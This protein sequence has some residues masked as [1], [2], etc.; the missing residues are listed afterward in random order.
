MSLNKVSQRLARRTVNDI[1]TLKRNVRELKTPQP[2]G[3]GTLQVSRYS[4]TGG[5][6]PALVGPVTIP[7]GET[8]YFA[9]TIVPNIPVRALYDVL[10][11]VWID[12]VITGG[13]PDYAHKFPNGSS[14]LAASSG[15]MGIGVYFDFVDSD[16]ATTFNRAYYV[17]INNLD[18]ASH[19]YYMED[20]DF[21]P[22]L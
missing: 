7:A 8:G 17:V 6:P 10:P 14:L 12:P 19:S 1:R 3:S 9:R 20:I 18:S 22:T 11:A 5:G 13:Q 16:D 21:A 4:N 15:K 2:I